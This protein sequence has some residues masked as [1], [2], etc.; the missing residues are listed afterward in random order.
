MSDQPYPAFLASAV[1]AVKHALA[2][3]QTSNLPSTPAT[4]FATSLPMAATLG[5]VP[6]SS[7]SLGQLDAQAS[8][9]AASGV[10]FLPVSPAVCT[11]TVQGRP[12]FVVPAF[13]PPIP[14]FT[15]S[16][17]TVAVTAPLSLGSISSL[18]QTPIPHKPFVVGP[19]FLTGPAKI[20][21]HIVAGKFVDLHEQLSAKLVLNKPEPQLLFD[22]RPVLTS[23]P[24][25]LKRHVD[26]IISWL[27]A[28]SVYCLILN[29]HFPH[30]WKDLL[31]CLPSVRWP[32]LVGVRSGFSRTRCCHEPYRVV[33]HQCAVI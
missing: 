12:D 10:G 18:A 30:R 26:D 7:L 14:A 5:G 4:S 31:H 33:N 20:V 11:S 32:S 23:T 2:A 16:T 13:A 19:G 27:E 24:K 6:S 15:S 9:L 29:S 22:G 8:G 3:E 21:S 1:N 25:K 17:N 28:L